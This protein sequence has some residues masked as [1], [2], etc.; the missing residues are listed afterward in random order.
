MVKSTSTLDSGAATE[1][2]TQATAASSTASSVAAATETAETTD[3]GF[4]ASA[5]ALGGQSGAQILSAA[6]ESP[7][8][9]EE[10]PTSG[11]FSA[12]PTLEEVVEPVEPVE[13]PAEPPAETVAALEIPPDTTITEALADAIDAAGLRPQGSMGARGIKITRNAVPA[14]VHPLIAEGYEAFQAGDTQ[15][16]ERAYR[17]VLRAQPRNR[18]AMLGLAAIAMTEGAFEEAAQIYL[19]LLS[20]DPND[21]VAQ[22]AIISL[23]DNVDPLASETRIKNLLREAPEAAHLYFGLGNV[24]A[25]QQ[26]W[27]EAQQ[28]FFDAYRLESDNADYA[29]NLAVSLDRLVQTS[30]ALDFYRVALDLAD[31]SYASFATEAV[32]ERIRSITPAQ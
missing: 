22:A 31:R 24:F 29:Y 14:R 3:G 19:A 25:R 16:A 32:L 18:D 2:E 1:Q 11:N 17:R 4:D 20:L 12:I 21:G 30:S 27:A 28:A 10:V 26:R 23:H 8:A 7:Q 15:A 6:I 5:E 13:P 9:T